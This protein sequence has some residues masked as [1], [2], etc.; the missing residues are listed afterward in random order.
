[1]FIIAIDGPAASGKS[2][3]ANI[4]SKK[5]DFERLDSGLLYRAVT[6]ICLKNS[7]TPEDETKC[8]KFVQ[9]LYFTQYKGIVYYMN[10]DITSHLKTPEI[11]SKV[12]PFAREFYIRE[13][14]LEIQYSIVESLSLRGINGFVVDGRDIGTVVFPNADIKIFI[15]ASPE[16]RARRRS[17]QTGLDF[18]TTYRDLIARDENDINRK[19]GPLKIAED[20]VV[21]NNDNLD[22]INTVDQIIDLYKA[23]GNYN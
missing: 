11:D 15:T 6:Y 17:E 8:K 10:E 7:I 12:G 14:I 1:M 20:A 5:L 9:S 16:I 2:S 4:I 22:L 13:K 23:K 18:E 3:A 19:H 21:I